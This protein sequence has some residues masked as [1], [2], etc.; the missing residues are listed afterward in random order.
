VSISPEQLAAEFQGVVVKPVV[1]GPS[2]DVYALLPAAGA[3]PLARSFVQA[4]AHP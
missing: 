2:R 3:T 4:L 1:D